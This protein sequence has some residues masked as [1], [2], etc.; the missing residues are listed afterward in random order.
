M[1]VSSGPAVQELKPAVSS[2][3][4]AVLGDGRARDLAGPCPGGACAVS[5]RDN[6]G[7]H[8]TQAAAGLAGDVAQRGG[9]VGA[10]RL[11]LANRSSGRRVRNPRRTNPG[12][13]PRNA[14][15]PT[16]TGSERLCQSVE[17]ACKIEIAPKPIER[18]C[19]RGPCFED[20]TPTRNIPPRLDSRSEPLHLRPL[21]VEPI[22][23][24]YLRCRQ[25]EIDDSPRRLLFWFEPCSK[26]RLV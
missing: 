13:C 17:P 20:I 1:T 10:P 4:E 19:S 18:D 22:P 2:L 15:D 16:T 21:S 11:S 12:H 6:A 5:P 9:P 8:R 3:G 25:S 14:Q 23:N 24:A 7:G 26:P